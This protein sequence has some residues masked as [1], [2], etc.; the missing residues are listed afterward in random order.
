M[1]TCSPQ[2]MGELQ[3]RP[4][5]SID[6]AMFSPGPQLSGSAGSSATTPAASPRNCGQ[7]DWAE[8]LVAAST[9]TPSTHTVSR[10]VV[11]RP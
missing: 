2:T 9:R 4:G 7:L 1:K 10:I 11:I 3:E 6:Q 5:T 8:T